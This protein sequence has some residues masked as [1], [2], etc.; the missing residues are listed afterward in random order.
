M[1]RSSYE[2]LTQGRFADDSVRLDLVLD[3]LATWKAFRAWPGMTKEKFRP[4]LKRWVRDNERGLRHLSQRRIEQLEGRDYLLVMEIYGSGTDRR[5]DRIGGWPPTLIGKAIHFLL[6]EVVLLWDGEY[7]RESYRLG[8][9]AYDFLAYQAY[10]RRLLDH[11]ERS[12]GRGTLAR[13]RSEHDSA[14]GIHCPLPKLVDEL[15]YDQSALKDA[16]SA[17]GGPSHAF[18]VVPILG[19]R[20]P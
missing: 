13:V 3:T 18:S 16:V 11:L 9:N 4:L 15:A 7:A 1:D 20:F 8:G 6:P 17:L 19:G 5:A 10:G 14:V 2:R 12:E